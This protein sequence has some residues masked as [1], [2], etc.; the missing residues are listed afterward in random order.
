MAPSQSHA[1]GDGRVIG[2]LVWDCE[3]H[4]AGWL[5]RPVLVSEGP[6]IGRRRSEIADVGAAG[7]AIGSGLVEQVGRS[8]L[9][10]LVLG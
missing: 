3:Y 8:W 2:L 9:V 10:Y 5:G 1:Y 6:S 4:G 7:G